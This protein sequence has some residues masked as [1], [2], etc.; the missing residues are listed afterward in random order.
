MYQRRRSE[1]A[2]GRVISPFL[3]REG[4]AQEKNTR[5]FVPSPLGAPEGMGVS[6]GLGRS[7]GKG[8]NFVGFARK[9][10]EA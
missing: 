7:G 10:E 6:Q 3:P 9:A 5:L 4:Y 1:G 8:W 2:A